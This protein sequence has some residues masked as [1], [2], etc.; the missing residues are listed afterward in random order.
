MSHLIN[1]I[2]SLIEKKIGFKS[3]QDGPIDTT[4][5]SG[6]LMSN[7]F[8]AAAQFERRLIQELTKA[9]W[10]QLGPEEEMVAGLR[11]G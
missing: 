1:L 2:A 6:E 3:I 9:G 8:S 11:Q 4:T 5:A 7:V 10:Q